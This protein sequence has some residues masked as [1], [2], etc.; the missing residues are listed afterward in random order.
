MS[1]NSK[2]VLVVDDES[3]L[4]ELFRALLKNLGHQVETADSGAEALCKLEKLHFDL[5][6]TD[7]LMP[8]MNGEEL[9]REIKKLRPQMSIVLVSGQPPERLSPCFCA[10]MAKPFSIDELRSVIASLDLPHPP[11]TL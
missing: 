1:L 9:A 2:V 3:A 11:G 5:V 8:E 4:R 7:F 10:V 6:F